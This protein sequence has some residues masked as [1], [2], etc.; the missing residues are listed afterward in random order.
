[1]AFLI[2][3]FLLATC[4]VLLD[5]DNGISRFLRSA[6]E[7][8]AWF[9]VPAA[10]DL[11]WLPGYTVTPRNRLAGCLGWTASTTKQ[12][13]RPRGCGAAGLSR[14]KIRIG[15]RRLGFARQYV[16]DSPGDRSSIL[17]VE[18]QIKWMPRSPIQPWGLPGQPTARQ[19]PTD[20]CECGPFLQVGQTATQPRHTVP[21]SHHSPPMIDI[22]KR[23]NPS[24]AYKYR[25]AA[26]PP[27]SSSP[28]PLTN[29]PNK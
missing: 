11:A 28:R 12:S 26:P 2:W 18:C 3:L 21:A 25:G 24:T 14:V 20:P 19:Q 22:H 5:T 27:P 13:R 1:M 23:C 16:G 6:G 7:G 17:Q 4:S 8:H 9:M 10:S 15:P 29:S